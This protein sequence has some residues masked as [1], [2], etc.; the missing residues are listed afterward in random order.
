M[1]SDPRKTGNNRLSRNGNRLD[2]T[3]RR[4]DGHK[5]KI[6]TRTDGSKVDRYW[7]GQG[8][9]DGKGHGHSWDNKQNGDKDSRQPKR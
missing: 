2:T 8:K 1:M 3:G 9:P 4:D 6:V 5:E 7:G